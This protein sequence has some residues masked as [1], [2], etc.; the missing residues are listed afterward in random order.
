MELVSQSGPI[1]SHDF[2]SSLWT[3]SGDVQHQHSTIT[4]KLHGAEPFLK[5]HQLCSYSRTSQYLMEPEGS[6]PCSHGTSTNP[7][8]EPDQSSPY[9]PI[10]SLQDPLLSIHPHLGLPSGLFPS[11]FLA[12]VIYPKNGTALYFK[13][14]PA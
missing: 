5:S 13:Q 3:H 10:L 11:G 7:Y 4:N 6:L 14:C 1:V 2:C 12:S 9:H 8:L